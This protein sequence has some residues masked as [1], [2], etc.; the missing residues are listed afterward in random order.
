[1][2]ATDTLR[3]TRQRDV[4]SEG[5]SIKKVR[6]NLIEALTLFLA[7]RCLVAVV[8]AV[9]P[10]SVCVLLSGKFRPPF[11]RWAVTD[12]ARRAGTVVVIVKAPT[13]MRF[14]SSGGKALVPENDGQLQ[15]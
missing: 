11:Q 15:G 10:P 14:S 13:R 3:D 9:G 12:G 1:M 6:T 2:R 7:T 5:S 8:P 4:A